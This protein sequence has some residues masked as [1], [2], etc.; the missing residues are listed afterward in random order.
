MV[1]ACRQLSAE[2]GIGAG[3]RVPLLLSGDPARIEAYAPYLKAL[4]RL[5]EV[6]AVA[7]LPQ[8]EA[9]V[10]IVGDYRLMLKIEIDVAAERERLTREIDRLQGEV[11]KAQTK[12]GNPSFVERAPEKVVT[13]ER[14]RLAGFVATVDKLQAQLARLA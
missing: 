2:M 9:P 7:E 4:V 12:L 11:K 10:A 3:K 5:S 8:A 6:T 14:E 13:Q 1:N